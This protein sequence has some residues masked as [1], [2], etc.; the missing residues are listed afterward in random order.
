MMPVMTGLELAEAIRADPHLRTTKI[1]LVSGAQGFIG[2]ER[3]DLFDAVLDKPY[4][5]DRLIERVD[6]IGL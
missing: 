4:N 5:V 3:T 2:R 6:S 1:F